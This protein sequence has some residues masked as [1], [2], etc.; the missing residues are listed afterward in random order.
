MY[1]SRSKPYKGR[2]A[3]SPTGPLH[4]GSLY[5]ALISFLDAKHNHGSWLVR[6]EDVDITRCRTKFNAIILNQLQDYGLIWD[7][8]IVYQSQRSPLYQKYTSVLEN[9]G[10]AYFCNCNRKRIATLNGNYDQK[11]L[12]TPP[13][14]PYE[15]CATR[16]KTIDTN[17]LFEDTLQ[18]TYQQN[19]FKDVGDFIIK[20]K[21]QCYAYQL[22]VVVDD[23]LQ[24]IS[25][26]VRGIDLI[27]NTPRQIQLYQALDFPVPRYAHNP[28]LVNMSDQK[29]SKQ[30]YAKAASSS[31]KQSTLIQLLKLAN[32]STPRYYHDLCVSTLLNEAAERWDLSALKEIQHIPSPF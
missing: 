6:M 10:L 18:S 11:C 15:T 2:F 31:D 26:I 22:A 21:D 25:H 27:D 5:T 32:Q 20:R 16:F 12:F 17:T 1:A 13:A 30:T 4:H 29:L 7:E 28:I 23:A 19:V 9:K 14:L 8:D 3:P 24:D